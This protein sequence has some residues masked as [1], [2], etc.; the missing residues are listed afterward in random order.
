LGEAVAGR[1]FTGVDEL[2]IA[3]QFD[4]VRPWCHGTRTGLVERAASVDLW[5][6]SCAIS[7]REEA[8]A[9]PFDEVRAQ[10]LDE[11]HHRAPRPM[12][13]FW[14]VFLKYLWWWTKA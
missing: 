9:R 11:W 6:S 1:E 4:E 7:K 5:L 8:Q 10:V 13:G 12:N 14:P 3:S 2:A